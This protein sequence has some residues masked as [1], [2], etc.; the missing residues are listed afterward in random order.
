M[1]RG[2]V[3]QVARAS[4]HEREARR[5]TSTEPCRHACFMPCSCTLARRHA[6]PCPALLCAGILLQH[7]YLALCACHFACKLPA[8]ASLPS[9]SPLAGHLPVTFHPV[10]TCQ[11][12]FSSA[13]PGLYCAKTCIRVVLARNTR[14]SLEISWPECPHRASRACTCPTSQLS[15]PV[16]SYDS[17]DKCLKLGIT[18]SCCQL[19]ACARPSSPR[20]RSG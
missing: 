20:W 14:L 3:H 8:A 15:S 1:G 13:V 5:C 9:L 16:A 10:S 11:S 17:A 2:G 7:I 19:P 6:L 18:G 4:V 12:T